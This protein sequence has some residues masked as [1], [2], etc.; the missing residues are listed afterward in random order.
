MP[1]VPEATTSSDS[2]ARAPA[3]VSEL[4]SALG[5]DQ[6][7]RMQDTFAALGNVAL[8]ICDPAGRLL[9]R[10]SCATDFC[11]LLLGT[12][13]GLA[14]CCAS[15]GHAVLR[16]GEDVAEVCHGGVVQYVAPVRVDDRHVATVVLGDRLAADVEPGTLVEISRQYGVEENALRQAAHEIGPADARRRESVVRFL[17]LMAD[18]LAT[19]CR[20]H[21]D[22]TQRVRE[23]EAVHD[24]TALFAGSDNLKQTLTTT[25]ERV[26]R[27]MAVK[28]C[29]IRLLDEQTGE[30]RMEA[31][32][33][34]SAVYL[35]K[36]P[37][38]VRE[39]PLDTAALGGE[40]VY[41]R[42]LV[43]DPHVRYPAEA[44]AE[45]LVS[46]LGAPMTYHGK[47]VGV[48]HVYTAEE[49]EFSDFQRAMLRSIG[50]QIAA[51]ILIYRLHQDRLS[52][53]LYGYHLR[54]A[55]AIQ[56]R[57]IPGSQRTH[58]NITFGCAYNPALN[59]G[60]DFF[61]FIELPEGHLGFCVAD[62]VGKGIPAALMMASVRAALRAHAH[63]IYNLDE[64]VAL[65]N[66][67][68]CRD[69]LINEF[70]TLF[71]GVFS[72]DGK[73][74]TYCNAGHEPALLLRKDRLIELNTGGTV[75]G[76]F[77]DA[78][79]SRGL[80]DL[81]AGDILVGFTDGVTEALDFNE[82][83]F[84][85]ERLIKSVR[86]HAKLDAV[87]LVQQLLWDVRRFVGL[88]D[89]SD[90]ITLVVAKVG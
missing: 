52:T 74:L 17:R 32:Y 15:A 33:N 61:D 85:H 5:A 1:D 59:V 88:T 28:A 76:V 73:R 63:S 84:G 41:I 27:V 78:V 82:Q 9:T 42:N 68:L 80:V 60:G 58:A 7:Q 40:T 49:H 66:A 67:Q 77:P 34:L 55:A 22:M 39:N 43:T 6:L 56:R 48:L 45:G 20:Q 24:L 90:D 14:A 25:A 29:S 8:Y 11:R 21:A 65:V 72:A 47:A 23:L 54:N 46:G 44:Q 83:P 79:F 87:G 53:E 3:P 62:V 64:I 57:M 86:K 16:P 75:L 30:L 12:P 38:L 81:R 37:V 10:P 18:R 71:Y 31:G 36:G 2:L 26:C 69:T 19:L 50:A 13:A 89:Q 35:N 70:T 4:I 51:A